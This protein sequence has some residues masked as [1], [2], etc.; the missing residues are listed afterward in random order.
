MPK[1]PKPII[2]KK[3]TSKKPVKKELN[4]AKLNELVR[5]TKKSMSPEKRALLKKMVDAR[6]RKAA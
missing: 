2:K 3:T 1:V 5:K 6:K 4:K